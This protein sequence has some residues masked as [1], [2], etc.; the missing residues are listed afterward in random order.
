MKGVV[1][2]ASCPRGTGKKSKS[3]KKFKKLEKSS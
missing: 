3:E 1:I 2:Y